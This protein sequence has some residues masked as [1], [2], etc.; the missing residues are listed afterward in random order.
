M[1]KILLLNGCGSSGKSS[2]ARSIQHI[3]E[4]LW[5]TFGVDTFIDMTAF[6]GKNEQYFSFIPGQN[7]RGP[8]MHVE[9][10]PKADKLFGLLPDFSLLLANKGHNVIIDEV[11]LDD[12]S[13]HGYIR[14]LQNHTVYFVGVFCD[15]DV[16][17]ERE[18]LR[19]DRAIGLSN[20]QF[21]R[22]HS[23]LRDYDLMVDTTN[24]SAFVATQQILSFVGSTLC[25]E[26]FLRMR[27]KLWSVI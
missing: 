20:D 8:L 15:L 4:E 6:P 17:Q 12:K 11:L 14:A 24:T 1:S 5:L 7:E 19:R 18:I 10:G 9:K 16:M 23:G 21:D 2:I 26:G 13:I 25:P 22:V 3:S 27:E